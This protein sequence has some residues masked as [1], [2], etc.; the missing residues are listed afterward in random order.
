MLGGGEGGNKAG[1]T[2]RPQRDVD[3]GAINRDP[4]H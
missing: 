3:A 4:F 2:G 1:E